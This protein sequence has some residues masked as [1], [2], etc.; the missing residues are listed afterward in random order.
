MAPGLDMSNT[1]VVAMPA[2]E[3]IQFITA[4]CMHSASEQKIHESNSR[5]HPSISPTIFSR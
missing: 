2:G 3:P 1:S 5:F 4:S